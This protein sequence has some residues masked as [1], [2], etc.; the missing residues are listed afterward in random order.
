MSTRGGKAIKNANIWRLN[1]MLLNNQQIMEEI[2]KEIK[3]CIETNE[4]ENM[5]TQNL[6][7]SVKAVLRGRFNIIQILYNTRET[8]NKQPNLTLKVARKRRY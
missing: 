4:N 1:D 6:W 7:D 2:K 3:I 8:S 5:R